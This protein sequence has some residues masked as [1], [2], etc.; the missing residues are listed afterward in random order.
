MKIKNGGTYINKATGKKC[1]VYA[2]A[3]DVPTGDEKV[4]FLSHESEAP[5]TM[6]REAFETLFFYIEEYKGCWVVL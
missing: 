6:N 5:F 1:T 3:K 2:V 4:V